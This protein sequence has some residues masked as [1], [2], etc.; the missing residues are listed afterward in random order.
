MST[1]NINRDAA[2]VKVS[3]STLAPLSVLAALN[4][5][6][7]SKAVDQFDDH[8]RFIDHALGLEFTAKSRL[9]E[10]FYKAREF[11]RTRWWKHLT[12]STTEIMQLWNGILRQLRSCPTDLHSPESQFR[13]EGQPSCTFSTEES[14]NGPT[15]MTN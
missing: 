1:I 2:S 3:P 11:S 8:F 5:G 6:K 10:F 12:P 13:C 7:F 15:T 9:I 14:R 4:G